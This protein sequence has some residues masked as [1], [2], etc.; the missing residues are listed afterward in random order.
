MEKFKM[1]PEE[2]AFGEKYKCSPEYMRDAN[3]LFKSLMVTWLRQAIMMA[4]Q[5]V[6]KSAKLETT[7]KAAPKRKEKAAPRIV[8]DV[9]TYRYQNM[10]PQ[11]SIVLYQDLL[12]IQ[13]I[14]PKTKPED[15]IAI[16]EGK[17]CDVKIKWIESQA[18]LKYLFDR[19]L[20]SG[21]ITRPAGVQPWIIVQSHFVNSQGRM[22]RDFNK[23]HEPKKMK[24]V[25]DYCTDKMMITSKKNEEDKTL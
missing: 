21:C 6:I 8:P 15:F 13:L 14:D 10:N 24:A 19:L 5:E 20:K 9:F 7:K 12:K 25:L 22:F 17:P 23:Q 1:S 4:T 3:E 18:A 16:F 11:G 2:V